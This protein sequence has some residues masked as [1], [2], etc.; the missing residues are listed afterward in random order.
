MSGGK[1]TMLYKNLI[2]YPPLEITLLLKPI[3]IYTVHCTALYRNE[4]DML[5]MLAM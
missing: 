1:H 5:S 3:Y 2:K 4:V